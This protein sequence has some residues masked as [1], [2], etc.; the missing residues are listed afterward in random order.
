MLTSRKADP[1]L[2]EGADDF[3]FGR[4]WRR[5]GLTYDK[6]ILLAI[7]SLAENGD[8]GPTKNSVDAA[9]Q[10]D[11]PAKKPHEAI[12]KH[13]AYGGIPSTVQPMHRWR[14]ALHSALR[15]DDAPPEDKDDFDHR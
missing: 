3:T 8:L 10:S 7:S 2:A 11:I 6:R 5:R 14:A 15:V 1:V 9:P 12:L 4:V 13:I